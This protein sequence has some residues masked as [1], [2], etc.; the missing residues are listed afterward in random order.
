MGQG[1]LILEEGIIVRD[2]ERAHVC[3]RLW[4]KTHGT[5][6]CVRVRGIPYAPTRDVEYH[7]TLLTQL[8]VSHDVLFL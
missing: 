5:I 7:G 4:G 3:L 1:I 8:E 6:E 2:I